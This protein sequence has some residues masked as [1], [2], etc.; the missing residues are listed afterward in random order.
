MYIWYG[1]IP[2]VLYGRRDNQERTWVIEYSEL[3]SSLSLVWELINPIR[4]HIKQVRT[5]N[6]FM[7][8]REVVRII[9]VFMFP[10][11]VSS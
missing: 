2:V 6:P 8:W 11:S 1:S 4:L 10:Y 5:R 7:L 9:S 3:A